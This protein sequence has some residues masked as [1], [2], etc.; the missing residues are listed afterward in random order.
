MQRSSSDS[1]IFI[2]PLIQFG[3]QNAQDCLDRNQN[4]TE[5]NIFEILQNEDNFSTEQKKALNQFFLKSVFFILK[6]C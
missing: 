4:N 2:N 5:N 6:H 3:G 1:P